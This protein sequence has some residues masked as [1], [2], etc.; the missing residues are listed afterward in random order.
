MRVRDLISDS[1]EW[2]AT[3]VVV[4]DNDKVTEYGQH[5]GYISNSHIEISWIWDVKSLIYE[6]YDI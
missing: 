5:L 6:I 3:E 2:M 1:Q 4:I